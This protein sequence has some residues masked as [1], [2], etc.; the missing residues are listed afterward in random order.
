MQGIAQCEKCHARLNVTG[1]RRRATS[2]VSDPRDRV[3]CL[4]W[5]TANPGHKGPDGCEFWTGAVDKLTSQWPR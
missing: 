5:H 1:T 3:L 2:H 4:N